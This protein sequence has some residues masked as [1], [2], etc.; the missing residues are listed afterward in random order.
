MFYG[1]RNR[2][3]TLLELLVVMAILGL[4]AGLI[5]P[6]VMKRLGDSKTK[7]AK[8]QIEE[9]ASALDMYKLDTDSYPSN[10]EGLSALVKQPGNQSAWN[11]PYLRKGFVPKDPW[12]QDYFYRFPGNNGTFDIYSLGAD[13]TEGGEKENQDIVSWK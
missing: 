10:Q 11:G 6:Q 9:L 12:G 1:V 7:T 13:K 2:G 4:L 5:G 3:F 8:L